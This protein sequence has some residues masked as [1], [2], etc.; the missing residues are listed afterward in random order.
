MTIT[1]KKILCYL[2]TAGMATCLFAAEPP[3]RFEKDPLVGIYKGES[4]GLKGYPISQDNTVYAQ[5][6]R[7]PKGYK[8]SFFTEIMKGANDLFEPIDG[9][10]AKDGKIVLDGTR[11]K[12]SLKGEITPEKISLTGN[13]S[14][15][16]GG[17]IELTKWNYVSPTMGE[18][19]PKGALTLFDGSD[20]SEWELFKTGAPIN[21]TVKDGSMT[22]KTF[23]K[24]EKGK[25]MSS[26]ITTKR[27]FG[28]FKLHIEFKLPAEYCE[29]S[30][31]R[32]NSGVLIG[33]IYEIQILDSF[34]LEG[35]WDECGAIYRTQRPR[36]NACLPPEEWQ[37]YDIYFTPAEFKNGECVANPRLTV[38]HNGILVQKD[39]EIKYSTRSF[40][41][42]RPTYKHP[43]GK[44]PIVLQDH[45]HEVS[46]R[47]IW[48]LEE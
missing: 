45:N 21:W 39:E 2:V 28:K 37:T 11:G 31:G 40:L 4:T 20:V 33:N 41:R 1:L 7:G 38:Y 25:R 13:Y 36:S 35:R 6:Y 16:K 5:V 43:Q 47:N 23:A 24:D 42:D 22:I 15:S 17:K 32:G 14:K 30:Q 9:L 46:F 19:A 3:Q 44:L 18:K 48:I 26:D 8:I 34:G 10:Q 29:L 27:K 12:E